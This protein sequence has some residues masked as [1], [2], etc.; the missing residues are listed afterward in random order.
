[1]S[2]LTPSGRSRRFG[3]DELDGADGVRP[4][5]LPG[6][7]RLARELEALAVRS[8]VPPSAAF[9]DRVMAALEDEPSPVPARAAGRAIRR[10]SVSALLASIRDAW[11]VTVRP[12]FPAVI[13][14]QAL[15]IVL[16]VV[17]LG[18]GTASAAAGALGLFDERASPSPQPSIDVSPAPSV[19]PPPSPDASPT[20]LP[21]A[22]PSEPGETETPEATETAEPTESADDHG[23]GS[24]S[25]DSG[26]GSNSGPG[27]SSGSGSGSDDAGSNSGSGSSGSGSDDRSGS[28][29][30][31]GDD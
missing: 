15:A 7:L 19:T 14:A 26:S 29:S 25:D 30:G 27:S 10:G 23:G 21:S 2:G 11:R 4:D 9:A 31:S 17:A 3:L 8:D 24:G 16:V 13:R 20:L 12:G 5:D 18:A 6:E 1:M 22:T 28:G